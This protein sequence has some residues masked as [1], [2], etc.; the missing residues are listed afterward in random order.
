MKYEQYEGIL[1]NPITKY[2]L[3][4]CHMSMP[5]T[6]KYYQ[7][8]ELLLHPRHYTNAVDIWAVGC[9]FAEMMLG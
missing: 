7:A 6:T 3:S 1:L 4:Q 5:L 2:S 9:M 8:P